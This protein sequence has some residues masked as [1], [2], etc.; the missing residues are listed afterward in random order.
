MLLAFDHR[1]F[2]PQG[3]AVFA[4]R[5]PRL[6]LDYLEFAYLLCYAVVP[7]G[8]AWLLLAGHQN[9]SDEFWTT[10][11]LASFSC[12]GVLPWLPSRA[13]RA[14]EPPAACDRSVIRQLNV[15]VLDG[16]SVQWNTFPSGHTAASLAVALTVGIHVPTAGV[17]LGIIAV[18]IAI[19]SV[20]GRYHYAADAI[21]GAVV[22]VVAFAIT[23]A[24]HAP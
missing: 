20:V 15:H 24:A 3:L 13:P 1:L 21:A 23:T 10:V 19:G 2:G 18:S 17:V 11:L 12:Y 4:A 8:W 16:A 14:V 7:A 5:A 22:A 6:T 9:Q